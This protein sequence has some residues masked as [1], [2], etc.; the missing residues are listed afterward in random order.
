[1]NTGNRRAASPGGPA[2]ST[3]AAILP[4]RALGPP[5]ADGDQ[6]LQYWPFSTSDLYNWRTQNAP[7]SERPKELINLLETVLFTHQPTWDDCQQLL[8]I[9]FTTEERERIQLEA[10]K[11]VP[12]DTGQPT[13]NPAMIN[14]SFPLSRPQWDYNTA[15][16][17][18]RLG[19]T[20]RLCWGVSKRP[21]A[22]PLILLR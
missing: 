6:P 16:G 19:S 2:N 8:Q 15:E 10:Q 4:L 20:A 17:K 22:G 11:L 7:F 14:S 1:M 21:L 13:A 3:S 12:G 18:E 9:L 5:G